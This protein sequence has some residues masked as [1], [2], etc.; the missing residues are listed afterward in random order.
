MEG[1]EA[2]IFMGLILK[3]PVAFACWILY[4]AWSSQPGPAEA[5]DEG[6]GNDRFHRVGRGPRR[7]RGPRRGPH[8]PAALPLPCPDGS[9]VRVTRRRPEPGRIP[10]P[11]HRREHA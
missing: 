1:L 2:M 5:P 10:T 11:A 4:W 7:P 8:G 6:G 3:I 9:E